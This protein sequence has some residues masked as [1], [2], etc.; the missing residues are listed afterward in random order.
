[1]TTVA[2]SPLSN[3]HVNKEYANLVPKISESQYGSIKQDMKEHGQHVP[4]I[5]NQKGEILDGLT[6]NRI[7]QELE[8]EPRTMLCSPEYED[9]L[10]AKQFIIN[11]NRNRRQLDTFQRIE[12]EYKLDPIETQ[13]ARRRQSEA[14]GDMKSDHSI[15]NYTKRSE[16][17]KKGRVIDI[18][19]KRAQVSPMTYF[20]GR[21]LIKKESPEILEK[22]RTGHLKIDKVYG[23]RVKQEKR[24]KLIEDAK[25][26]AGKL[27][28]G[29]KLIL[30]DMRVEC[31]Q[32]PDNSI[33]CIFTDP[34]YDLESLP[35]WEELGKLAARAL[36]PGGSL[37]AMTGGYC[38]LQVIN[39]LS[40]SG[41]KFNWPCYMKHAGNTEAMHGNHAIACGKFLLWFYKGEKL[42][43]TTLYI[44]DFVES[45]EPDKSLH[46]WAQSPKEAEHFLSRLVVENQIVLDPFMG[47]GTTGVAALKLK[48]QFIGVEIDEEWFRRAEARITLAASQ[49]PE[50]EASA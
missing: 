8:I 37:I 20:K 45:E 19:A 41:L 18:A 49:T 13:L 24:Q 27:P 43:D 38:F 2:E 33:D 6:R 35:L 28:E 21:E 3:I 22:L 26:V 46:E 42:T 1:M 40:K 9:P 36:K 34:P 7:C 12:L 4:I 32:I 17:Q 5:I 16:E 30:G 15:Q 47:S 44:T 14:G 23:R 50:K 29:F 11:I 48:Y 31:N 10:L 39:L 25:K